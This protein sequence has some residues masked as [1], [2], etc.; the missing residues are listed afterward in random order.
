[1]ILLEN[2][3]SKNNAYKVAANILNKLHQKMHFNG[4]SIT[5]SVSIG[6][7]IYPTDSLE[8]TLLI[9]AADKAMYDIKQLGGNAIQFFS[10]P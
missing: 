9:E 4:N 3:E 1:M 8:E 10:S 5:I 2:I 6:I 7:S